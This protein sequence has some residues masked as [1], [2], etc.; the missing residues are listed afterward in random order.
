MAHCAALFWFRGVTCGQKLQQAFLK[1]RSAWVGTFSRRPMSSSRGI[2]T[3]ALRETKKTKRL[4]DFT[5]LRFIVPNLALI[6]FVG[7]VEAN[8]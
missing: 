6:L 8:D 5:R 3:S 7:R 4:T 1:N 2:N